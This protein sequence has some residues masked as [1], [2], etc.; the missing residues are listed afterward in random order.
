M[1]SDNNN[2][3]K[4]NNNTETNSATLASVVW[5]SNESKHVQVQACAAATLCFL[6][7]QPASNLSVAITDSKTPA[8]HC[9]VRRIQVAIAYKIGLHHVPGVI[10]RT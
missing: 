9:V 4:Y 5:C 1:I 6:A 7:L 8:R 3:S 10:I 2:D